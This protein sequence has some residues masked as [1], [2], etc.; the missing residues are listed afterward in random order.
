MIVSPSKV[1]GEDWERGR[2]DPLS[3]AYNLTVQSSVDRMPAHLWGA[4]IATAP[5]TQSVST[6]LRPSYYLQMKNWS[7]GRLNN[8]FEFTKVMG[9]K[10]NPDWLK[11]SADVCFWH[12]HGNAKQHSF[13]P[14]GNRQ[15][16]PL[17]WGSEGWQ[18]LLGVQMLMVYA[19]HPCPR[20]WPPQDCS[21]CRDC[22][23]E[24]S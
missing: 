21:S 4:H 23:Y 3:C 15:S 18:L 9:S 1:S 22:S 10:G 16:L 11:S 24:I 17:L 7:W 13:R 14:M 20:C 6:T 5:T 2:Q 19:Q 12:G 8:F